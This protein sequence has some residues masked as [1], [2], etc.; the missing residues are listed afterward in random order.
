MSSGQCGAQGGARPQRAR[1]S[2]RA[3]AGPNAPRGPVRQPEGS[4][5]GSVALPT[6]LLPLLLLL[7]LCRLPAAAAVPAAQGSPTP[8]TSSPGQADGHPAEPGASTPAPPAGPAQPGS[9]AGEPAASRTL[10]FA[11]SLM[12]ERDYYR[13]ITEYKRFLHDHPEDPRTFRARQGIAEAYRAGGKLELAAA[14]Y[15]V[16]AAAAAPGSA[17]REAEFQAAEC[18]YQARQYAVAEAHYRTLLEESPDHPRRDLAQY[19]RAWTLIGREQYAE[20]RRLLAEMSPDSPFH[21]AAR[22]LAARLDEASDIRSRSPVVAGVLAALLPGSGHLYAGRTGDAALSLLV[23]GVFAFGTYEAAHHENYTA[24]ALLG[25]FGLGFYLGNVF[26]AVNA[27]ER[28]NGLAHGRFVSELVER[29]ES[30]PVPPPVAP[31][32][33]GL[34]GAL[35]PPAVGVRLGARW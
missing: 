19:R 17:S 29:W 4:R 3:G 28:E 33:A 14:A 11:D 31:G 7:L 30:P 21:A 5:A 8:T 32:P 9:M 24:A 15:L 35:P 10:G 34:R 27:A 16:L 12:R 22:G 6:V 1:R 18:F 13:A 25:L 26:G 23:N 20:A 2:S